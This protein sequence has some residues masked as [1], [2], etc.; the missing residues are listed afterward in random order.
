MIIV[1]YSHK[2]YGIIAAAKV[3]GP[4]KADG[5]EE[6]FHDVDF[7]TPVPTRASGVQT[8]KA[9]PISRV[10]SVTGKS[11]YWARTAKVPYLTKDEPEALLN[12]LVNVL[13]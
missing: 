9:V 13:S 11:F 5:T 7:L 12:E 4:T 3:V 2:G 10:S 6:K 1:F 8:E